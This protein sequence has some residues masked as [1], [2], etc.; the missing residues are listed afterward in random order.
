MA[1]HPSLL[2]ELRLGPGDCVALVGAGGKTTLAVALWQDAHRAGLAAILT[3]TTHIQEPIVRPGETLLV[4]EP[5][6][7]APKMAAALGRDER[8]FMAAARTDLAVEEHLL[9]GR[10]RQ[11]KLQGLD[12]AEVD[13]LAAGQPRALFVV[14]ADGAR[15]RLL[16]A[17]AHYEP[18]TPLGATRLLPMACADVVGRPLEAPWIHRPK[19]L[20]ALLDVPLGAALT[21]SMVAA[22]LAHRQGGL[23]DAPAGAAVFAVLTLLQPES[24][25][26][27]RAVARLLLEGQQVEAV[28]LVAL[29]P[30]LRLVEAAHP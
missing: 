18:Q 29:L 13:A 27:A 11:R 25:A 17:P 6:D 7:L 28:L 16:K 22:A 4:G 24:L 23:K 30:T 3:T 26:A 8:V 9:P 19:L 12:P 5:V 15:H 14:E 20:A 2:T 10:F 1:G 21:P